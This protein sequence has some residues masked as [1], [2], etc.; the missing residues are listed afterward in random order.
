MPI[1]LAFER[2][3]LWAALFK[4]VG[5][6]LL[7][8]AV[9][10]VLYEKYARSEYDRKTIE[11]TLNIVMGDLVEPG[12]W[13]QVRAQILERDSIRKNVDIRVKLNRIRVVS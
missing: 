12:I 1:L 9:V 8:A 4:D 7:I 2:E 6:A 3:G 10:T 13:T 11:S 5:M